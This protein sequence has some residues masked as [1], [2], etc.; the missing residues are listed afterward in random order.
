MVATE[1]FLKAWLIFTF[2]WLIAAST[3]I[4]H[5]YT[6]LLIQRNFI[7]NPMV[8][9]SELLDDNPVN[10]EILN[11]SFLQGWNNIY[12]FGVPGKVEISVAEEYIRDGYLVT[13]MPNGSSL[14]SVS[15]RSPAWIEFRKKLINDGMKLRKD[16]TNEIVSIHLYK[17]MFM[18]FG[19]PMALL[20]GFF[21]FRS[22]KHY[23][24]DS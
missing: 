8:N 19:L 9:A 1:S 3:Q 13:W 18:L 4:Y 5:H 21:S 15:V 23:F 16:Q 6:S 17:D 11:R 14:A 12:S 10:R 20:L 24:S 7:Y 22:M 2:L